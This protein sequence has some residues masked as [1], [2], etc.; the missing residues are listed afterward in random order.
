M[1][2]KK[3]SERFSTAEILSYIPLHA[4][5]SQE[6]LARFYNDI[7]DSTVSK[8]FGGAMHIYIQHEFSTGTR[9][10]NWPNRF[11]R[12]SFIY[13]SHIH[14]LP[15]IKAQKKK[16]PKRMVLPSYA[17]RW[18]KNAVGRSRGLEKKNV[19]DS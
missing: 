5:R 12:A 16:S 17:A 1:L 14:W 3:Y 9:T 6:G 13:P 10:N 4:S 19:K 15:T 8:R 18:K 2:T 11:K 7:K